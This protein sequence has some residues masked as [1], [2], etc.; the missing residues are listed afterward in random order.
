M[1]TYSSSSLNQRLND[2][3]R[4]LRQLTNISTLDMS[5]YMF[6][7]SFHWKTMCQLFNKRQCYFCLWMTNRQQSWPKGFNLDS[8]LFLFNMHQLILLFLNFFIFVFLFL[9][10]N[11]VFFLRLSLLHFFHFQTFGGERNLPPR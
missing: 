2:M 7:F 6:H 4:V 8:C 11:L 3:K 9:K 5:F 1:S 10:I